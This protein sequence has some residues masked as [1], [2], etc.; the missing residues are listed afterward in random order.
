MLHIF[1]INLIKFMAQI[2]KITINNKGQ[3]EYML[4]PHTLFVGSTAKTHSHACMD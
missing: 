3:R 4:A 2:P 1:F